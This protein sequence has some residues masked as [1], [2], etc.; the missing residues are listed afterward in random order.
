GRARRASRAGRNEKSADSFPSGSL[1]VY[2]KKT[3]LK[4]VFLTGLLVLVPLAITLWVLGLVIGTMD[5]TLLL[6]PQSW[7]PEKLLGFHL[8]GVGAL[9]TL[10]FIFIVGLFTQNFV[11]QKLVTWW[12]AIVRHIPIVGPLYTSVKQVSDT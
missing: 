10:A 4:S 9:L 7:Q 2:M 5:Q 8:P 6:L 3:T 1:T 12:Y 11:G